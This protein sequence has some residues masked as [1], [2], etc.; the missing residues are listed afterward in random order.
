VA[1]SYERPDSAVLA[2]VE[3]LVQSLAEDL[4]AWRKRAQRAETELADLKARGGTLAG[5]ELS[6]VRQRIVDLERENQDLRQRV[7]AAREQLA[8]LSARL[9]FLEDRAVAR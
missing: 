6:Q 7:A 8:A 4:G 9:V 3:Q 2:R 1:S 5:P